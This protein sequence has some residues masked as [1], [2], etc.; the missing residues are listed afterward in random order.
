[1][2]KLLIFCLIGIQSTALRADN[3]PFWR[4]DTA[5]SGITSETDLPQSW[6]KDKNVKWR[7]ELPDRGNST[8]IVW[9]DKIF[10]TQ[11]L[12]DENWRGLMC[13][14]REDGRL[15]WKNG[16]TYTEKERTHRDNPYCSASPAIDGNIVI[17][18]YGSAGMVAYDLEGKE[19]WKRDFGPIDHVWGN[20]TSPVIHGDLCIHYH[21]PSKGAALYGLN[22]STGE[23]VWK[24]DEPDWDP[25][26]R[27]DGFRDQDGDGV[28]GSFSTPIIVKNGGKDL[29]VMSFPKELKA[30][31]P[32]TGE[33]IWTSEGLNPLVYT[34]PL[35][36]GDKLIAMGGYHGNSIGTTLSGE[37]LWQEVRHFGGIGTG[38]VKDGYMYAQDAGGVVYC[39]EIAT[40]KTVWR[41]RLPGAGKSWGSFI[42]SGDNI[43]TL[44]QPGD[45]VVFKADPEKFEVVAQSNIGERTNSSLVVSDGEIFIRTYEALWCISED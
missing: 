18:S 7:I 3:W 12:E 11:P 38:I 44:S 33:V 40:G 2:K 23:T 27:T 29:L 32:A 35:V 42:L 24:W 22:K 30:F 21:G 45:T 14:H 43:Y 28:I 26:K 6:G 34:S 19:I 9:E 36:A 5:G 13:Y 25:G 20:S 1:M 17:A 10:V 41:D 31:D 4:G 37:R 39:V 16:L 8:P 15:L